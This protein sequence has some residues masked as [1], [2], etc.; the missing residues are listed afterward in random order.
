MQ[1]KLNCGDA[2]KIRTLREH[3]YDLIDGWMVA[4]KELKQGPVQKSLANFLA[5]PEKEI[6]FDD[7]VEPAR[8]FEVQGVL[9]NGKKL[10]EVRLTHAEFFG[11]LPQALSRHWGMDVIIKAR[12]KDDLREAMQVLGK[13][14]KRETIYTYTG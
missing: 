3:G 1:R 13:N 2:I 5:W 12:A 6:G 9:A 8:Y 10:A 7:G 11:S 14:R 4:V